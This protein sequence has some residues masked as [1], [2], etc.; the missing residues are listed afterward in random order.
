[1]PSDS[2]S[3]IRKKESLFKKVEDDEESSVSGLS[4]MAETKLNIESTI[5]RSKTSA[6]PFLFFLQCV[7]DQNVFK[8]VIIWNV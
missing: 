6:L 4:F 3:G 7:I 1:M 5:F 8:G 2:F